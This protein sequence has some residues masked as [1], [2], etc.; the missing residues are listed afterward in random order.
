MTFDPK[1]DLLKAFTE[2]ALGK[3]NYYG[4]EELDMKLVERM[5]EE[6]MA[7]REDHK[8]QLTLTTHLLFLLSEMKRAF[9]LKSRVDEYPQS[10]AGKM[11]SYVN[12]HLFEPIS[13]ST[14]AE[15]F[16]LSSSQFGRIFKAATG[17]PPWEYIV[18]KRLTVAKEEIRNGL[19]AQKAA[20]KCGFGNYS[21]FYRAYVGH[22]GCSPTG[23]KNRKLHESL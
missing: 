22:F 6:M 18:R 19:S 21:A 5:F 9:A 11:V 4:P 7:E 15:H 10:Q 2:R 3:N 20:E 16:Y 17:A 1:G 12:R 23:E 8:R 13:V 14:L